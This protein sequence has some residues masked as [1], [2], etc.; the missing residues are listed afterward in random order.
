MRVYRREEVDAGSAGNPR[1]SDPLNPGTGSAPGIRPHS[2]RSHVPEG[3]V[4]RQAML[5]SL[6]GR[7]AARAIE[8]PDGF[9]RR[10]SA[11][12]QAWISEVTAALDCRTVN[13]GAGAGTES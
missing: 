6:R 1:G 10:H 2:I 3:N 5:R 13:G 4:E 11:S 9:G 12:G 7:E 8:P